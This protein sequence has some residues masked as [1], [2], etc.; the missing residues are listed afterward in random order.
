MITLDGMRPE[1]YLPGDLSKNNATLNSLRETGAFA[2][3]AFPPY[4][5]FTYPGHTSMV[6]GAISPRAMA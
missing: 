6:T 4:P 5:S 2:K 3:A 1:F